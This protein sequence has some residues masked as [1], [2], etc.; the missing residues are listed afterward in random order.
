MRGMSSKKSLSIVQGFVYE[1]Q[2]EGG[3]IIRMGY[4]WLI[5]GGMH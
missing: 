3:F 5:T 2:P 1:R 4:L